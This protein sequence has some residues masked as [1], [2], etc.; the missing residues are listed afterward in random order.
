MGPQLFKNLGLK[1]DRTTFFITG[2]S[3]YVEAAFPRI[4]KENAF[5]NCYP[6]TFRKYGFGRLAQDVL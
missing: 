6:N 2:L 1:M 5:K 3:R 4:P